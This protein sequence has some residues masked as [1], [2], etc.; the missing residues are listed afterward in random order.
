MNTARLLAEFKA[1]Q[2]RKKKNTTKQK[3]GFTRQP[4]VEYDYPEYDSAVGQE[5][6]NYN[7]DVPPEMEYHAPA[8]LEIIKPDG[9][10]V[11]AESD[12]G[13]LLVSD[14]KE[15]ARTENISG[16]G[17]MNKQELIRALKEVL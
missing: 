17:G 11:V 9:R 10:I 15:I 7:S 3:T 8:G 5:I 16:Y 1:R 4:K 13:K 14:L 6:I 2:E 12:L